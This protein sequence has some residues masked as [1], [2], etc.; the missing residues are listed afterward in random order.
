MVIL[1]FCFLEVVGFVVHKDLNFEDRILPIAGTIGTTPFGRMSHSTGAFFTIAGLAVLG[2]LN[3]P[4]LNR[5]VG[6]LGLI[7]ILASS[8]LLIAY[9]YNTPLLYDI[10]S[11][12]PMALTTAI[13]F[14]FLGISILFRSSPSTIPRLYFRSNVT[15]N[16]M[17]VS[18]LP[19][20]IV[21]IL[22]TSFILLFF[23]MNVEITTSLLISFII[24]ILTLI[25]SIFVLLNAST[26]S[27]SLEKAEALKREFNKKLEQEVKITTKELNEALN[28]EKL[29]QEQLLASSQFKSEFMAS[30]SH[31]LRTPLNS[32]IG[33]TDVILERI[34]GEVNE[35]QDKYLNN[36]KS[37]ALHLLDLINDILDIAKIES[38][39][40]E[41]KIVEIPLSQLINQIKT[42]IKPMYEKKKL[43]FEIPNITNETVIR[44]D[45]LR[46]KE[47]LFNLLSNAVKYTQE[48]C[49]KLEFSEDDTYWNFAVIDTGIG[50]KE[51]DFGLIFQDFKRIKSAR[52]AAI[53]GTGLGLPL[54]KRLIEY[55]GGNISFTSEFGKGSTFTF[56]IPTSDVSKILE[57]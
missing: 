52:V 50:I 45:R 10:E 33:F 4:K 56:T 47:I 2:I 48:G 53:E 6:I 25:T 34:S 39:K 51:E 12:V 35:E 26:I 28:Q 1:L 17:M 15:L 54:T 41:L 27:K 44:V 29:Y 57:K 5:S 46:F 20:N 11:V 13:A 38:G 19:L 31:E 43:T 14:F 37:S 55:H 22:I 40:M 9:L 30:M 42:M 23:S 32:I 36:V 7:L 49:I 24:I 21:S 18:F 8:V 16:R 3:V